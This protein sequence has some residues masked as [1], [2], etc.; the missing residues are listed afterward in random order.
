LTTKKPDHD[1]TAEDA[2]QAISYARLL[3]EIAPYAILTNGEST[4]VF[5]VITAEENGTI[6]EIP[7][8]TK[9]VN[10]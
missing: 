6:Q 5:D 3:R 7:H 8:G 4:K 2:Q 10:N 1:L 9:T